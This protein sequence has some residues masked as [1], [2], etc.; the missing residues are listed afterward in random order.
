[1]MMSDREHVD[2]YAIDADDYARLQRINSRL[3]DDRPLSPDDRRDLANLM[4]V[5][6]DRATPFNPDLEV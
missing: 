5:I 1:M 6:L 3:Y 2:Y 4:R